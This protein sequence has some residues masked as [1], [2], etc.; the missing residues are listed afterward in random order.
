MNLI[1]KQVIH[2]S[3]G[4]GSVVKHSD[5]RIEV[6][7]KSGNK[8]FLFPDAFGRYLTLTDPKAANSIEH[9]IQKKQTQLRKEAIII[10]QEREEKRK[11]EK[12]TLEREKFLENFKI[13]PSS[14]AVFWCEEEEIENLFEDWTVFTGVA[15]SGTKKGQPNR[16]IRLN[17]NS[18]C[19]LTRRASNTSEKERRIIGI[20]M[21]N[22][23]FIGKLCED[24]MVPS[25]PKH[26]LQF[27]T[28][29]ADKLLF[30][31]YYLNEKYPKNITWN[32]G[33]YRYFDNIW[34]AQ[35]L[36]DVVL[37]K[38]NPVEKENAQKFLEYFCHMNRIDDKEVPK[39]MGALLQI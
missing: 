20:F 9:M 23:T 31:N 11:E 27:T 3:F 29:E 5:S 18:A 39:P 6:N 15:K 1:N 24:G 7:F 37:L 22:E 2:K 19:L 17:K 21:V 32:S 10:E 8:K 36:R 14:Q 38:D 33:K 35:I 4:K 26:R 25:D 34:M 28:E 13:H 12:L 16:P 30:W